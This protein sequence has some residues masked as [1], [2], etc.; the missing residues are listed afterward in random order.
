[1]KLDKKYLVLFLGPALFLMLSVFLYP[2]LRTTLMSLFDVKSVVAPL[3]EW[4]FVGLANFVTLSHTSVFIRSMQNISKLWWYGGFSTIFFALLFS[5]AFTTN[6]K[7]KKFFRAIVYLP[8]VIAAIAVGY[9]WLL[10]IYNSRFGFMTSI[11][12]MLHWMALERFSW[13]D[14]EHIFLSMLIAFVYG[15]IGYFMMIFIAGIERIP[16]D[17]YEAARMEGAGVC[18]QF[19][20]ITL[21]LIK[22][23]FSTALVLWT[24]RTMGFFALSQVFQ[25]VRTYTPMLFTYETLFGTEVTQGGMNAGLAASSAVT[26]TIIVVVVSSLLGKVMKEDAI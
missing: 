24:T 20:L 21:P 8:N 14:N 15:N 1:M 17:F 2:V 11:G 10:Y 22:G 3:N 13:L 18:T 5:V 23:V 16:I 12:R 25:S 26:M 6:L 19:L 7:G 9:M 4:K